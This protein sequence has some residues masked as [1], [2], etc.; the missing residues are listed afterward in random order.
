M[1]ALA[2]KRHEKFVVDDATI[3]KVHAL[4]ESDLRNVVL[5]TKQAR[6]PTVDNIASSAGIAVDDARKH[7]TDATR[8]GLLKKQFNVTCKSCSNIIARVT[9]RDPLNDMAS[10]GVAC[11]KCGTRLTNS[12]FQY[13][14]AVASDVKPLLEHSKWMTVFV[15]DALQQCGINRILT[16]IVDGPHEID[17][18][19]NV[20]GD[21]LL[22][23][24]KDG[25]FSIGHAYSFVGKCS[26]YKPDQAAIVAT[27][28]VDTDV[29]DYIQKTGVKAHYFESLNGLQ[30]SFDRLFTEIN[31]RKLQRLLGS[32]RWDAILTESVLHKFGVAVQ[33][34]EFIVGHPIWPLQNRMFD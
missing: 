1:D 32:S 19:A 6:D 9:S 28:G 5:R 20:D 24:L 30:D 3:K 7:L 12:S 29:R 25:R 23:E 21:F 18:V 4:A 8:H 27:D 17:L 2:K 10:S 14:Y 34:D 11:A 16:E 15:Q 22:L 33:G 13:C 31:S 26:Q